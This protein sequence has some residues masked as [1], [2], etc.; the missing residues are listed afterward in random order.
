M[1]KL[2]MLIMAIVFFTFTGLSHAESYISFYAGG[3]FPDN[4]DWTDNIGIASSGTIDLDNT[5][6]FGAKAGHWF[7]EANSPFLGIEVEANVQ[8]PD[9]NSVTTEQALGFILIPPVTTSVTANTTLVSVLF[10][11]LVR[12]P[13]GPVRPYAGVGFGFAV[14]D[15]GDQSLAT[16]GTFQSETDTAFAWDLIAGLDFHVSKRVS[17]FGEYKYLGANF[18]FPDFI[19]MDID[20]R[21]SQVYGGVI[22]RF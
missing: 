22:L 13:R 10:N 16:V 5:A 1:K 3:A 6:T 19:G 9:W 4:A 2:T 17:L 21:A 7:N 11:T 20:Y 8:F 14:W 12:Y 15:I 18:S